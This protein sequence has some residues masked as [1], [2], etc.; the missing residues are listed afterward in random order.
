MHLAI[1][2]VTIG[3]WTDDRARTGCTV[4]RLPPDATASGEVRGGAPATREFA[5][6]DPTR[7]VATIDAVVL[8]G[9][10]AFGLA[11]ADGVVDL[12]AQEGR[13]FP[14]AHGPV[15]I[16][17][18]MALYDLGVGD[19]AVRPDA[20]AGRAALRAADRYPATG[21]VG[22]GTGATVGKWRGPDAARPGG[23]GI[24]EIRRGAVAVAAVVA[25]NAAGDVDDGTL[26]PAMVEGTAA[27]WP[28]RSTFGGDAAG[29]GGTNTT[30]GVVVTNAAIDKVG[31]RLL[32]EGAHDGLARAI[33]PPHMRS[34]GDAMVAVSAGAEQAEL[35]EVRL[36]A[37]VATEQAVREAVGSIEE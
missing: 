15:P 30:I 8:T 23:L 4:I 18:A 33:V 36:M 22:A 17:V 31:C 3:H 1:D 28:D 24:V 27:P 5:L 11:A 6:L 35:D 2:G 10:S 13:G 21:R 29:S 16:V 7:L 25:V 20:D 32:A 26:G 9:G 14:T 12:L 37:V 19:P 34:D